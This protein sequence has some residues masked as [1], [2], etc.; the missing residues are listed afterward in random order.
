[1]TPLAPVSPIR[2]LADPLPGVSTDLL[3]IP[4]FEDHSTEGL[5]EVDA[6]TGG[7]VGRACASGEFSG[8]ANQLFLAR[9]TDPA[10][11]TARVALI[12]C[13]SPRGDR[14]S[15]LRAAAAT[16]SR[17]ATERRIGR[18]GLLV[19]EET[20]PQAAA[21]AASEG[22]VLGTFDDRRYKSDDSARPGAVEL[23]VALPGGAGVGVERA[24]EIGRVVA[25]STNAARTLSNQPGNL[26]TPS[27]FAGQ[28][29]ELVRGVGIQTEVL[30]ETA[31]ETL[32][33]GLL[34]GV[35]R[36]S[37]EPPR[38]IVMRHEP[39]GAADRPV[40][41]LVG[42]GV[43]FDSGGISIKPADGM[44]RMKEDMS[45]GAAVVCAMRAIGVLA[46]SL[47]VIG[48]VPSTENMPGGRATKPGDVLTGASGT[49]VEV[50]NTD[51][52]GRLILGDALWYAREL[53][54]TH[55]VDVA[56]LTGACIVALGTVATG[57]FATAGGWGDVV[58][59]AATRAGERVWPLPLF[60]EYAEQMR[61][62]IADLVNAAGRAGGAAT[63]AAFL[64]AFSGDGP[65]AH[66]DIAGTAWCEETRPDHAKGATGVMVRTLT[67]L[68]CG[69]QRWGAV[70]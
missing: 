20:D 54:A 34:L 64:Q 4:V 25:E 14:L 11:K 2:V 26:L 16:A 39:K 50:I 29:V 28:A 33:M 37:A 19:R 44:E 12:G 62:E 65:W 7:E 6:A 5:E 52:E 55:L 47:R 9:V 38:V 48:V 32:G 45:G 66:L 53:G 67:E 23:A 61:S 30:D 51:A 63:A 21:R 43:T 3:A 42:K 41:G 68:A 13:G 18:I 35:S 69:H 22:L 1:M 15:S 46:P 70:G 57:L 8:K 24:V 59:D 10:W 49:T 31:I 56:T 27:V 60:P 40:L 36:G 58:R 17:A